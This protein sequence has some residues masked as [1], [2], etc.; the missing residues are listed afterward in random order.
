[1]SPWSRGLKRAAWTRTVGCGADCIR[2]GK[3]IFGQCVGSVPTQNCE[4][5]R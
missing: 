2:D 1:M 5:C 3:G 4:V